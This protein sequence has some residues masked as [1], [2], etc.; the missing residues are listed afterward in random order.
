M[1]PRDVRY[2][3]LAGLQSRNTVHHSHDG[4]IDVEDALGVLCGRTSHLGARGRWPTNSAGSM[5]DIDRLRYASREW[6]NVSQ[7][8]LG[9]NAQPATSY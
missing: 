8:R 4:T 3:S 9:P 1:K 7:F 2:R 6:T 5:D